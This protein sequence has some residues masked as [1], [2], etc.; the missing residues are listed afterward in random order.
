[1]SIILFVLLILSKFSLELSNKEPLI[2]NLTNQ[3]FDVQINNDIR[4]K[5]LIVFHV[6]QCNFC[7]NIIKT[8]EESIAPEF[9]LQDN[10]RFGFVDCD[11]NVWLATRFNITMVPYTLM[12]HNKKMAELKR[13]PNKDSI[14]DF[15]HHLRTEDMIPM[16]KSLTY[17]A[18]CLTLLKEL[19]HIIKETIQIQ[20]DKKQITF[21]KWEHYMTGILLFISFLI[22]L[23][24]ESMVINICCSKSKPKKNNKTNIKDKN[25]EE[26]INHTKND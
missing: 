23:F 15:I 2:F 22:I 16:P 17:F 21:I 20:L 6:P 7:E 10:V 5:W 11:I 24:V 12:I 18:M 8:I 3:S 25:T 9:E 4:I 26:N 14:I 1:M 13:T 19:F